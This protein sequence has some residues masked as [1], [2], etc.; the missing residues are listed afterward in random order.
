MSNNMIDIQTRIENFKKFYSKEN[1]RPLFG[2]FYGSEY[3]LIRYNAAKSLPENTELKPNDFMVERYLDDYERMFTEHEALGG[4][5][6]WS[7]SGFWGIPWME[8]L[9]GCLIFANHKTGSIYSKAPAY[10]IS[11][12]NIPAFDINN[13]WVIK[14]G[15]FIDKIA[16]KS[17]GRYPIGTTRMRGISDLLSA[18]YDGEEFIFAM[19]EKPEETKA[20]CEKL[21][22]LFIEF[23]KYQLSK[24]PLFYNG[25]G[26]F[27]YHM[28]APEGTIWHQEDAAA[29]ISPALYDEFI[30]VCDE[31]IV[32]SFKGCIMHQHSTGFVPTQ[33]YIDM[34]M[35]ALELHID[36]G[37]PGAEELFD[38]HKTI[39]KQKPLI[40]WGDISDKDLDWIF[41]K[42]PHQG[43]AINTVVE[44]AQRSQELWNRYL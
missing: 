32:R 44:N 28:W 20:V 31:R 13:P 15:E 23:G 40:I 38:R 37:G 35:T 21:T 6:I 4:D 10:D 18:L 11:A 30:Q 1:E 2:F 16:K 34:G 24:I 39:L 42:L 3:P 25:V 33:A 12:N 36:S 27:Y 41:E 43:L 9:L 14:M 22:D 5:F 17:R 8:A 7:A 19:M 26:S 29:L